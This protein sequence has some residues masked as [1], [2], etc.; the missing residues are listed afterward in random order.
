MNTKRLTL[1][2]LENTM[3]AFYSQTF[4]QLE[5]H[6]KPWGLLYPGGDSA[7]SQTGNCAWDSAQ[8]HLS[9]LLNPGIG[10]DF[11]WCCPL[12]TCLWLIPISV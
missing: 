6:F 5:H 12:C 9:Y 8:V 10:L 2:F 4:L 7:G 1:F 11:T 3:E